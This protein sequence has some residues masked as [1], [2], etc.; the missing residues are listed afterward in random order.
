MEL[1]R[2]NKNL[3]KI[4][5]QDKPLSSKKKEI[6]EIKNEIPKGKFKGLSLE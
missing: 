2:K 4:K 3:S 1:M 5:T 6:P